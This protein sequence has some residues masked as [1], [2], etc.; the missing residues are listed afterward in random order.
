MV[1]LLDFTHHAKTMMRERLIQED[2]VINA[3][4]NPDMTEEKRDDEKHYLKQIPQN[5]GKFLRVIVNP[6]VSPPRVIT[7][8]FDRR[9]RK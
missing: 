6:S 5:S 2:W 4:N 3:V 9:V 8:F 7:A 1:S